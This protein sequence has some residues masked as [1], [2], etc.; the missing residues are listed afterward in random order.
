MP[1]ASSPESTSGSPTSQGIAETARGESAPL[2]LAVESATQALSVALL[3]GRELVAERSS[4][5][6]GQH[7]ELLLPLIDRVLGEA[8]VR[9]SDIEA[10][11]VSIGPG[12]FTSLRV[13]VATVKGLAFATPR[14]V[15]PVSTLA[16]LAWSYARDRG[17]PQDGVPI[18][19]VLD[20]RRG[21][22]YAAI[23]ELQATGPRELRAS[24]LL[25][26]E[27]LAERLPR[28]C[29]LVG[30]GA[31]LHRGELREWL[32]S[33]VEIPL[34]GDVPPTARSVGEIAAVGLRDGR[35]IDPRDLAP[36]YVRRAEA[37][38]KRTALPVEDPR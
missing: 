34:D 25:S 8:C 37:E 10:F 9:E 24:E 11:A 31:A 17:R 22:V 19:A 18:A 16:A 21:E 23:F 32:G 29:R 38:A 3:R 12:S 33:E 20:A 30:E 2:L 26:P 5:P 14:L 15:V 7:A 36:H 27:A 13:G 1:R 28:P 35:A 6:A 4:Q